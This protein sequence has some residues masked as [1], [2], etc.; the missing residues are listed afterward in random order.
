MHVAVVGAGAVGLCTAWYLRDLGLDVTVFETA[1][2]GNGASWGNA[3]Q[4]LPS[5]AVPL[6]EPGN[7]KFALKSFL[8]KNSPVTAPRDL[9]LHLLNYLSKFMQNSQEKRF[10]DGRLSMWEF[11]RDAFTEYE[12]MESKG[13]KTTRS[14]GPFTSAFK[15]EETAKGM[16]KD[17]KEAR[18]F[19]GKLEYESLDQSTLLEREPLL[20]E[21]F[22]F[23]LQLNKQS[24]IHPPKFLE[25]LTAN[26]KAAGVK[27]ICNV[28]VT[29]VAKRQSKVEVNS[30][31]SDSQL[32]D[33]VVIS[34]GAWLNRLTSEHGVK[35]PVIAGIGYSMSV[36]VPQQ[37]Q[38]MLYLPDARLATT[39]YG[40]KLRISTFMQMADVEAP[41]D[42]K[43]TERLINLAKRELP[44]A[45]WETVG[46]FWSGGRPLSGDGKPLLGKTK[47]SGVYVNAG[48][49][50]WGITLAPIS[51]RLIADAITGKG[52]IPQEFDP[53]R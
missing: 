11:G 27:I 17:Y 26:L 8:K 36:E 45:H 38:G 3:G 6:S 51:G 50:M 5:K 28:K 4:I 24:Y 19:F 44:K 37:T 53:T 49:G 39:N 25:N 12:Y 18:E 16:V 41:R 30:S 32:F 35:H 22:T 23:G 15:T 47:T 42:P 7:L 10:L 1:E 33:S 29:K 34:T 48:H 9:D 40:S 46:E 52:S 31:D 14:Q 13:V 21:R 20:D 43:R 2:P